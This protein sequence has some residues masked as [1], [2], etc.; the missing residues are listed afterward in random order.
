MSKSGVVTRGSHTAHFEEAN[1]I[2]TVTSPLG[3]KKA[4]RGGMPAEVLA[5]MLLGE[6]I[7]EAARNA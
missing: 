5:G 2:V 3:V 6:L 1:G 4:Q 7:A